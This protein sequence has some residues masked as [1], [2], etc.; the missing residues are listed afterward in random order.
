M[1]VYGANCTSDETTLENEENAAAE[2]LNANK[3]MHN[4][5]F[6]DR[7]ETNR[8][9]TETIPQPDKG[10]WTETVQNTETNRNQQK[11]TETKTETIS[12]PAKGEW[13]ETVQKP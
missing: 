13:T 6:S 8:N 10:E 7:T 12:Q 4:Q 1:R 2:K 3:Q 9:R 5:L 11:P